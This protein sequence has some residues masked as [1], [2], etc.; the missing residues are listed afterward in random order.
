MIDTL[1]QH[2]AQLLAGST[3][4][5]AL[6]CGAV[7]LSRRPL[8]AQRRGE[9]C[10]LAVLLFVPA[11]LLP[12]P[13]H[14]RDA[15]SSLRELV[16]P[17][18]STTHELN[19]APLA[20]TSPSGSSG[21]ASTHGAHEARE[22]AGADGFA[23][24]PP[25]QLP[26]ADSLPLTVSEAARR[27]SVTSP[28]VDVL[29][30]GDTG[31]ALLDDP[32]VTTPLLAATTLEAA[33]A[34]EAGSAATDS[35]SE[36]AHSTLVTPRTLALLFVCGA[37]LSMAWLALGMWRLRRVLAATSAAPAWLSEWIAETAPE[38]RLRVLIGPAARSPFCV[39]LLRQTIVLPPTLLHGGRR[40]LRSVLLHELA[41]ARHGDGRGRLLLA[42][43]LPLLW[44]H[45][46]YWWLRKRVQLSA[47]L[48]AD[49]RAAADNRPAY[50]RELLD[51]VERLPQT[52]ALPAGARPVFGAPHEFT[53]R[54][55]MLLQRRDRLDTRCSGVARGAHS[56]F[57]VGLV[58]LSSTVFGATPAAAQS[59]DDLVAQ[60]K[61][62]QLNAER[63]E[64]SAMLEAM[65][66]ELNA[67][68]ASMSDMK[69]QLEAERAAA[70]ASTGSS[71]SF[72]FGTRQR[73]HSSD[74]PEI[75]ELQ[76]AT[77]ERQRAELAAAHA[78]LSD[79][80][81]IARR[82]AEVAALHGQH[83]QHAQGQRSSQQ[84]G[85]VDPYANTPKLPGQTIAAVPAPS[86]GG[87]SGSFAHAPVA[88]FGDGGSAGMAPA[89]PAVP[90]VSPVA[91]P[92]PTPSAPPVHPAH[93]T[94][95][96]PAAFPAPQAP[97]S[98]EAPPPRPTICKPC[99]SSPTSRSPCATS[100]RWPRNSC[101]RRPSW[102]SNTSHP[103]VSCTPKSFSCKDSSCD[104]SSS[105]AASTTRST[106]RRTR[107]NAR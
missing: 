1:L 15:L 49:D 54:I 56:L 27:R 31:A 4:L 65:R 61:I 96:A 26:R 69:A 104:S 107:S 12:L 16:V 78:Q 90:P 92:H 32:S 22:F 24:A 79:S 81:E 58:M 82:A 62:A 73:V 43:A 88:S 55:E 39:G 89:A 57:L 46:L 64:L 59:A 53:R 106:R 40:G 37:A 98:P 87:G 52:P 2:G 74:A 102:W 51:L 48:L 6:G 36:A 100:W 5:L 3:L 20:H 17:T 34:L 18:T 94:H 50:A 7:A 103:R 75:A 42:L 35:P 47:E 8:H 93:P 99:S 13:R 38:L 45:P 28:T 83:F 19:T 63:D 70:R 72:S 9:L 84:P 23:S 29:Q 41:H 71:G 95:P 30:H 14:G 68:H 105:S 60:A 91:A 11:A 85:L 66:A 86:A 67:M 97:A 44:F 25:H 76:R 80:Q 33:T 101:T 77:F 10:L 21:D